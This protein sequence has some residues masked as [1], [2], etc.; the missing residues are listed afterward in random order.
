MEYRLH[1][2]MVDQGHVLF[3]NYWKKFK[4]FR[5]STACMIML[6]TLRLPRACLDMLV[7]G[8]PHRYVGCIAATAAGPDPADSSRHQLSARTDKTNTKMFTWM[9]VVYLR[10]KLTCQICCTC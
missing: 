1:W 5:S 2:L 6:A 3:L 4:V 9:D 8:L 7:V 10:Q